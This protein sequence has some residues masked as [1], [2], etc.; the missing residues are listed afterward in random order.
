MG[1]LSP[2]VLPLLAGA[3]IVSTAARTSAQSVTPSYGLSRLPTVGGGSNAALAISCTTFPFIVGWS[4]D[5][6]GFTHAFTTN[7]ATTRDL[8]TLGGAS[9]DARPSRCP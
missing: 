5:A 7:V 6:A 3:L 9:S 8:G 4:T 2:G 1:R